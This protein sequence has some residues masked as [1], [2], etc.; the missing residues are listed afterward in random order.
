MYRYLSAGFWKL[1]MLP[2]LFAQKKISLAVVAVLSLSAVGC[3]DDSSSKSVKSTEETISTHASTNL[4]K[5]EATTPIESKT[6]GKIITKP[7]TPKN[8]VK[9]VTPTKPIVTVPTTTSATRIAN[10]LKTGDASIL[11]AQDRVVL[12]ADIKESLN[13]IRNDQ[14]NIL[15][16]ILTADSQPLDQTLQLTNRTVPFYPTNS[17]VVIPLLQGSKGLNLAMLSTAYDGRGL[18]Y[19]TDI[20]SAV[21][22]GQHTQHRPILDN[23]MRWLATGHVDKNRPIKLRIAGV[24]YDI[25]Q[26]K[27]YLDGL[28]NVSATVVT[29]RELTDACLSQADV[30]VF[31]H[32]NESITHGATL[33]Q[34]L[35]KKGKGVLYLGNNWNQGSSAVALGKTLGY[36]SDDYAGNYFRSPA[37]LKSSQSSIDDFWQKIDSLNRLS[38][39]IDIAE[40]KDSSVVNANHPIV[41]ALSINHLSSLNRLGQSIFTD[42]NG[43]KVS[44][45]SESLWRK[46]V[47]LSDSYRTSATYQGQKPKNAQIFMQTYL[48]D[49]WVDYLREH[50]TP[51]IKGAGEYMPAAAKDIAVSTDWETIDITLPQDSGY[52]MIGRASIMGKPVQIQVVNANGARLAVQT[53]F[54]RANGSP[55]NGY[56]RPLKPNSPSIPLNYH[57]MSTLGT[58]QFSSPYGGPLVL[59]YDRAK[60]NQTITLKVKGVAKYAHYDYTKLMTTAQIAQADQ[61]LADGR[62][63]WNTIKLNGGEIQQT[64][65]Y[66]KK[67][68]GKKSVKNYVD[69]IQNYIFTSNQLALGYNNQPLSSI[70]TQRC[71]Q[72]GWDCTG[73]VHNPK[74]IQH[75]VGYVAQCGFLCSGQPIDGYAAI[76]FGWGYAHELGHN[77]VQRTMTVA[78]KSSHTGK[79]IGCLVECDNNHLA[80]L[81]ELRQFE[82]LGIENTHKADNFAHWQIYQQINNA[83]KMKLTDEALRKQVEKN[84]WD[85]DGY[86]NN[87]GKRAFLMQQA[88]LFTKLIDKKAKPD[89]NG[90]FSYFALLSIG[91]RLVGKMDLSKASMADKKAFGLG[92][93]DKSDFSNPELD[94]ILSSVILGYDLKHLYTVYGIPLSGKAKSSVQMLNLPDVPLQFYALP[95]NKANH[96]VLGQWIDL[97]TTG[98]LKVYPYSVS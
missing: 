26:F 6:D 44:N 47:L 67:A 79:T 96:L 45:R 58:V 54:I 85:G 18:S 77:T 1:T 64:I 7:T 88:F 94:Y 68:I 91:D 50:Q 27:A 55:F 65:G 39:A 71:Q 72:L 73:N 42:N 41:T 38:Q 11:Q 49:T 4:R 51:V 63:G 25:K 81:S 74:D 35:M 40:G 30:V 66:A 8:P 97:P 84:I 10:A 59:K 22:Q 98:E 19:A 82:G 76:N 12:I 15:N 52:T 61:A 3:G 24:N 32:G 90:V 33:S 53:S 89:S 93:Y 70:T 78:F 83:R 56:V 87:N 92:A 75:F 28:D 57:A 14:K 29:C 80:G 34:M 13:A 9:S 2:M 43:S 17:A 62:F 5:Q 23:A 31:G 46:L 21:N 95:K 60:A 86:Q 36:G 48:A 16:Q 20:I 37:E 69:N